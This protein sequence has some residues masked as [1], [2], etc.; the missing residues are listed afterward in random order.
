MSFQVRRRSSF[1]RGASSFLIIGAVIL[2]TLQLIIYSRNRANFPPG[3]V[4]AGVPVGNLSRQQ[5]AER[6]LEVYSLPVELSYENS[7]IHMEPRTVEFDLDLES[8]IAAADLQRTSS[9]FWGGFWNY[10]WG[11][12]SSP[13]EV[14]LRAGYSEE[15][16]RTYL[17]TEIASR[18]D[19]PPAPARPVPGTTQFAAGEPGTAVNIDSAITRIENALFSPT[20]RR[21]ALPLQEA[22]PSRPNLDNLQVQLEQIIEGAGFDGLADIYFHDLESGQELHFVYE[23]GV[24]LPTEPDVSFTAASTIKIPIMISVYTRTEGAPSETA[25]VLLEAMIK[26]S[27]N[28]DADLLM[29]GVLDRTR[30]PL[31]VT[32]DLRALGLENTFLAGQFYLGAP[33]LQNIQTAARQRQDVDTDPDPYNQTTPLDMG[34]LLADIHQCAENGGGALGAVFEGDVTQDEC[35]DMI[36][37]LAENKIAVLLEGGVPEGTRVAHKHGWT[38][39]PNTG[40][41]NTMGDA[42]IIFTPN[43]DYVAVIFLYHPVQIIFTPIEDMFADLSEAIYNYY[44]LPRN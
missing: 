21:V 16:L 5:A 7:L 23:L 13:Q 20:N 35:Q 37:L 39:N 26:Q 6:L 28:A 4:V 15:V 19:Q 34:M 1:L 43:G 2:L 12:V 38:T 9:S 22:A 10:L 44:T 36:N 27:D 41:I 17:E 33:L 32:E 31:I 14:P 25:Q 11:N 29:E 30:G 18:Y 42:G 3:L 24:N 8:M 40:V